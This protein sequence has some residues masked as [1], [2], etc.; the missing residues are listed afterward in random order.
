MNINYIYI[1][2]LIVS[3]CCI[4][5]VSERYM[6]YKKEMALIEKNKITS[7]NKPKIKHKEEKKSSDEN[8]AWN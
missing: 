5:F 7:I 1:I 4:I 8:T 2:C 6:K 3:I